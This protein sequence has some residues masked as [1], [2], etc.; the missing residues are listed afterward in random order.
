MVSTL[1]RPSSEMTETER[2]V[3]RALR[4][5]QTRYTYFLLTAA[6]AGIALAVHRTQGDALSRSQ[7]LLG[8]AVMSWGLS[9]LSGCIHLGYVNSNLFANLNLLGVEAGRLDE[10]VEHPMLIAPTVRAIRKIVEHNT[11]WATRFGQA[12]FMTLMLG[13][14]LYVAWHVLEMYLRT[15]HRS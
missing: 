13:G 2:E 8:L 10:L 6:G 14:V 4:D 7:I 9:V 3:Y 15:V 11:N 12:Q 5:S 1:D